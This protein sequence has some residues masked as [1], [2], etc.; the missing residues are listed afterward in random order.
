[1]RGEEEEEEGGKGENDSVMEEEKC[2]AKTYQ[3]AV[4]SLKEL[5][6][7]TSQRND[8]ESNVL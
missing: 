6:E 4:K 1:V 8:N 3:E 5:Q 7:F 2:R